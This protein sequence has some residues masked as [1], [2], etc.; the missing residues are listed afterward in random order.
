[1]HLC[2]VLLIAA[3]GR[4]LSMQD[5]VK[6]DKWNSRFNKEK[7]LEIRQYY[8]RIL[9]SLRHLKL[10]VDHS[11]N[12]IQANVSSVQKVYSRIKTEDS[13]VRKILNKD[14][15]FLQR[16]TSDIVNDIKDLLGARIVVR[17]LGGA[18]DLHKLLTHD[19]DRFKI[20]EVEVHE[21]TENQYYKAA[22]ETWFEANEQSL[23][24][25]HK[26]K[27][28]P[29]AKQRPKP[30]D[31]P[32]GYRGI[33]YLIQAD[34]VDQFWKLNDQVPHLHFELQT[35]T[36][37]HD[38]WCDVQHD[39]GYKT[40][41]IPLPEKT[42]E[43]LVNYSSEILVI[44]QA[45]S[46]VATA[47]YAPRKLTSVTEQ[48]PIS[49]HEIE[50]LYPKLYESFKE[51]SHEFYNSQSPDFR[52]SIGK[53]F[54]RDQ[55]K[56]KQLSA[57]VNSQERPSEA[58]FEFAVEIAH[59]LLLTGQFEAAT[60]I[61][62][63]VVA[64]DWTSDGF[65][66]IRLVETKLN[67]NP[68][69]REEA[70]TYLLRLKNL[71]ETTPHLQT[72]QPQKNSVS[73]HG[74]KHAWRLGEEKLARYFTEVYRA[75]VSV[76]DTEEEKKLYS[77]GNVHLIYE[78]ALLYKK[79]VLELADVSKAARTRIGRALAAEETFLLSLLTSPSFETSGKIYFKIA[80]LHYLQALTDFKLGKK[81]KAR[82]FI[83]RAN[84]FLAKYFREET[85]DKYGTDANL[86]ARDVI[87]LE[88]LGKESA[89]E[90]TVRP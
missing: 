62:T 21:Y 79:N 63:Y 87:V 19:L 53:R 31:N 42:A 38:V 10:W 81:S 74:A 28:E 5:S 64:N 67:E 68:E 8:A 41:N 39:L 40:P 14:D 66:F 44:E 48:N 80:R 11:L 54:V 77:E 84:S 16:D 65:I 24:D 71:I 6:A 27:P 50:A 69:N 15:A 59:F 20:E 26:G 51:A 17:Y 58:I 86:L 82:K 23:L 57:L 25:K 12:E 89:S 90:M 7:E 1:M 37:I 2:L 60:K 4:Y 32:R 45:L 55:S 18:I 43:A 33:H 35:H 46:R 76:L 34:F 29:V 61:Y 88:S 85:H 47:D 9:P 70:I 13:L 52:K 73:F 49:I 22:L 75:T 56:S 72:Q 36:S 3:R 78:H 83:E 30:R